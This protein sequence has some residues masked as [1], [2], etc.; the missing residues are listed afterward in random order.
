MSYEYLESMVTTWMDQG[1]MQKI[2][3]KKLV[4]VETQ[5]IAE[6]EIALQNY[7]RACENGRGAILLSVARGKVSEGIDFDHHLGRAVLMFGI[8]YVYT[9]SRVLKARLEYLAEAFQI[10]EGAFLTFDAMRHA[11]QCVGRAI[12]GKSDYGIMCFADA[13]SSV[14]NV[15]PCVSTKSNDPLCT[16]SLRS[17]QQVY[18]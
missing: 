3:K 6:T 9:Q 13:V 11:A 12:R 7:Q 1:I 17:N 2:R 14:C 15:K 5:D 10:K 16:K 8:P 18:N 4:F